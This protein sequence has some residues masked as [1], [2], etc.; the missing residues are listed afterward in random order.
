MKNLSVPDAMI[1][2]SRVINQSH[3]IDAFV[4]ATGMGVSN[5]LIQRWHGYLDEYD[6]EPL[7]YP[8]LTVIYGGRAKIRRMI[9]RENLSVDYAMPGDITIVP[10]DQAMRWSINRE[11][12][13]VAVMFQNP[14]T[15]DCLQ[16]LYDQILSQSDDSVFVGSFT[17]AYIYT[18]C[19]HLTNVL[20]ASEKPPQTYIEA[21]LLALELYILNY[22]GKKDNGLKPTKDFYSRQVAYTLQRLTLE[23]KNRIRVEDI[24]HELNISPSYL[25]RKFKEEVGVSPHH[26]LLLKRIKRAQELLANTDI[27]IL[28]ISL[29]SGFSSQSH[30]TRYFSKELGMSPLKFRQRARNNGTGF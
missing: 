21:Q 2:Q 27:D 4:E 8:L 23:I 13:V 20:S 26:L 28:T 30:L 16:D 18:A 5:C 9:D 24:A 22:L 10:R 15:C 14:A 12:D 29:E 3:G 17:N 1:K 6:I 19:N 7:T 11:V 25:T